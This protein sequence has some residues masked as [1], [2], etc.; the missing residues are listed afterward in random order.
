MLRNSPGESLG[1]KTRRP[2]HNALDMSP[3]LKAVMIKFIIYSSKSS[4]SSSGSLAFLCHFRRSLTQILEGPAAFP[5]FN[6]FNAAAIFISLGSTSLIS[7]GV[8]KLELG[9]R[10]FFRPN[11]IFGILL[12]LPA[13]L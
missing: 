13:L 3:V 9:L 11:I 8:K 1:I 12:L 10:K 5:N 6:F 4:S 7:A 2:L